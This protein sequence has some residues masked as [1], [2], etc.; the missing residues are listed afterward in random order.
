MNVRRG[1]QSILYSLLAALVAFGVLAPTS[2][3]QDQEPWEPKL[4]APIVGTNPLAPSGKYPAVAFLNVEFAD[5]NLGS[6]TGTLVDPVW[7]LTAAHCL[8]GV[9][10]SGTGIV[11]AVSA[12]V[13]LG[14]VDLL[15]DLGAPSLP[16]GVEVYQT[17][18]WIIR[19]DYDPSRNTVNDVAL[20]RLPQASAI[21]P[22]PMTTNAALVTPASSASPLPATIV[23]YG[24]SSCSAG[25][26]DTQDWLLHE[27]T[28]SIYPDSTAAS[29]F[30][31][32]LPS[33]E[34]AHNFFLVPNLSTQGA[35]CF[36]DSGGPVLAGT[37]T[38]Y[39]VGVVSFGSERVCDTPGAATAWPT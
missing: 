32:F 23:G 7:V 1:P 15:A 13:M 12:T 5:G 36:G 37:T 21:T 35:T 33:L 2:A 39:V 22:I 24:V 28:S 10:S 29:A 30:G 31:G 9:D 20:I 38:L 34:R 16:P 25:S 26:C 17:Q 18:A 3:A 4:S 11:D 27:A 19:G 8:V 6:C 14:S